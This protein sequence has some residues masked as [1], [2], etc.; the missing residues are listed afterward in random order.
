MENKIVMINTLSGKRYIYKD[1]KKIEISMSDKK[2]SEDILITIFPDDFKILI[3]H[4]SSG[5]EK[6]YEKRE[7]YC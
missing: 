5:Q 6:P 3:E 2:Q 1:F 4:Y 7:I